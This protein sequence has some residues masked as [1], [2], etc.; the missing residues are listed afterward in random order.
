MGKKK[1]KRGVCRWCGVEKVWTGRRTDEYAP[2]GSGKKMCPNLCEAGVV[3][4]AVPLAHDPA[5]NWK[6]RHMT[7]Y[8]DGGCDPGVD[9]MIRV[10]EENR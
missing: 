2:A 6:M 1:R 8:A 10:I 9:D 7:E 5:W 4:W 3:R